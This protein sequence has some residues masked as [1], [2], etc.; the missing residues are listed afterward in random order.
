MRYKEDCRILSQE[1]IGKDIFSM[2]L[3]TD[4]IASEARPGQFLSVYTRD[5]SKLLPRPISICDADPEKGCLR[6]VYRVTGPSSGTRQFSG[7]HKGICLPVLGPLGNGYPVEEVKG[8]R[9]LLL[10]GG[11]GIPPLLYTAR[12]LGKNGDVT[13]V[14]GYRDRPFMDQEFL[15]FGKVFCASE[16]GD[17]SI[18]GTVLDAVREESLSA[19]VIFACGPKPMLRAVKSYA[20][21]KNI[22][23]Y[24]SLEERMACG[25]GACLGCV[26][27]S[28][29]KDEHSQVNNKRVCKD[30]PVFLSD[31]VEL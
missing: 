22:L 2:W 20:A 17:T 30:G 19:D 27:R 6:L 12:S 29:E 9:I 26:V 5:A 28:T 15:P 8:K 21:E 24:L 31:E 1:E 14:L 18:R 4:R 16:N 7:Y 23:C 10:G 3:Q 25:I 13:T 11:I